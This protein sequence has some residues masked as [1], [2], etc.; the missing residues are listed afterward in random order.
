MLDRPGQWIRVAPLAGLFFVL[1][2]APL[3][4]TTALRDI[5]TLPKA[6][7][8]A[9]GTSL[10]WLGM[11]SR[12]ASFKRSMTP[13]IVIMA[14]AVILSAF[15]SVDKP[16]SI[17]GPHQQQFYALL[18]L[19]LCAL[20]YY[21]A[22]NS[23]TSPAAS[24]MILL[25][26]GLAASAVALTQLGGHGFMSWTIQGD[27]SGGTFGS[28]IFLGSYLA[29]LLPLAWADN[30]RS[31]WGLIV[32]IGSALVATGSRG[33]IAAAG[34][35]ILLIEHLRGRKI[36]KPLG[37]ILIVL[38]A[39][40]AFRIANSSSSTQSDSGRF[41]VWRIAIT[42]W[43]SYPLL[44]WGPDTFAL[45]FRQFMTKRFVAASYGDDT[46]I[47]LSAHNDVLQVLTTMGLLGLSCYAFLIFRGFRLL[48]MAVRVQPEAIGIAGALAALFVN[49]KFNPIP[50]TVLVIAA[51][52]LGSLD[53]G[54]QYALPR[55]ARL[56]AALA[57]LASIIVA[58]I[59]GVMCLAERH[60]RIGE[61]LAQMMPIYAA[62]QFN[63]A[64]Q[65]NPFDIWYTQRQLDYFWTIA[66]VMPGRELNAE[67]MADFSHRVAERNAQLHPYDPT[68][69]EMRALSFLFETEMLRK[70]M[71]KEM[72]DQLV[73]AERM[74]PNFSTYT[75]RRDE[76]ETILH[77]RK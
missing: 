76:L 40:F 27:R 43:K 18:P 21:A 14:M 26:G 13:G 55:F 39:V 68:A 2:V 64:A 3:F 7:P 74:A 67:K 20:A 53:R 34:V 38:L 73:I 22:A 17:L 72:D 37:V 63:I 61:D 30:A 10:L 51:C 42:S 47:Q 65:I 58:L 28:P 33:S 31:R 48:Q 23:W 16:L 45:A 19:S 75:K 70:I 46:F 71:L 57:A 44:G 29:L 62:E 66:P 12:G 54:E 41:E 9:F 5:F 24:V 49:A 56:K 4:F 36:A 6:L 52:L 35:G 60:Q 1:A 59:F 15:F 11:I 77:Q 25:L 8:L 32:L 69:Y 50:L